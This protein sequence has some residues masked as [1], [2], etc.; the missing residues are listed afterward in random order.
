MGKLK[1]FLQQTK[2]VMQDTLLYMTTESV[3]RF[4]A[5]ICDF[6]PIDVK[7]ENSNVVSNTYYTVE[8]I[9]EMG[10]PK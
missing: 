2:F 9:A 1:K 7:V 10:A 5:A 4:V 3:K 8:Q 6:V